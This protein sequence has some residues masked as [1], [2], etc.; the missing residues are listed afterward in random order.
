M[1]SH[2]HLFSNHLLIRA[3]RSNSPPSKT[4]GALKAP[5]PN[6]AA[7]EATGFAAISHQVD[8]NIPGCSPSP[9]LPLF[10]GALSLQLPPP[11]MGVRSPQGPWL[12]CSISSSESVTL[13]ILSYRLGGEF[14]SS[15]LGKDQV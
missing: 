13:R 4:S 9:V 15:V 10:W 7:E 5:T 12:L 2:H 11:G 6:R 1:C 3:S 8:G 14:L